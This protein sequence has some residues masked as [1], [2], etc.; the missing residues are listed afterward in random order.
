VEVA[1]AWPVDDGDSVLAAAVGGELGGTM[2]LAVNNDVAARLSSDE[3]RL[4]RGFEA[5]ATAAA[6]AAGTTA[7]I[8][9]V[10]AS[11]DRPDQ[12]IEI[13]D[14]ES[15]TAVFGYTSAAVQQAAAE[16]AAAAEAA[17]AQVAGET[18][19]PVA[20]VP[21]SDD[22]ATS[23]LGPL[24]V[25]QNVEMNV[26]VELGRTTMPIRELLALKPGMVVEIDRA[27]GA[28]IDVLV[29][30]RL[31]ALGEVVVIDEEFGIRITDIVSNGEA[32]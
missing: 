24:N 5:A 19:D 16:Q 12:I 25:L 27:A 15:L 14:N 18:F 11:Q 28:P 3:T 10:G 2:F 21:G 4:Q 30:G 26:T 22:I 6:A 29:N 17:A 32:I 9:Q 20:L 8:E 23:A 1:T 7:E 31:I 13:F